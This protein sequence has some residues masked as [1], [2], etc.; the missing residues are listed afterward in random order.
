MDV[1]EIRNRIRASAYFYSQHADI[2]R[3]ADDLTV[4]QVEEALLTCEILEEYPDTGRG[5]ACL[6]L[7][8]AGTQPIHAVCGWRGDAIVLVTVYAPR[9]PHFVDLWTRGGQD[10]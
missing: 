5:E 8:F 2:E 3:K 1:D 6:V 7:D 4:A 10:E 9:L